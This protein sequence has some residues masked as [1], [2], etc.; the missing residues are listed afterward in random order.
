MRDDQLR[1]CG[2]TENDLYTQLRQRGVFT[3]DNVRY[4]LSESKGSITVVPGDAPDDSDVPLV[5]AGIEDSA[6]YP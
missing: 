3:L 2:L 1:K 6:G 5:R 4:V